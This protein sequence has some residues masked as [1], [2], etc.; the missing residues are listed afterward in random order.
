MFYIMHQLVSPS[1][2]LLPQRFLSPK[3]HSPACTSYQDPRGALS[4]DTGRGRAPFG[5][6]SLRFRAN[7]QAKEIP[8]TEIHVHCTCTMH[9]DLQMYMYM[10]MFIYVYLHTVYAYV[11]TCTCTVHA[12]KTQQSYH[13][14]TL[15]LPY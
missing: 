8:G 15:T 6:T 12:K 14:T 3:Y 5:Q 10:Y 2:C 1:L 9:L 13:T 11:Y 4:L 7:R